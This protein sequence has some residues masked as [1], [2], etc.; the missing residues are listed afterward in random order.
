MKLL[1]TGI[2]LLILDTIYIKN[3][4]YLFE[5]LIQKIQGYPIIINYNGGIIAYIFLILGLYYFIIKEN[6]SPYDAFIL[7]LVIYGVYEGTNLA[8]LNKWSLD[9]LILDTLW[10]GILFALTTFIIYNYVLQD[11]PKSNS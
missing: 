8:L 9:I 5:S 11:R 7:G 3:Y 10:G 1:L 6:K 2:V 4:G